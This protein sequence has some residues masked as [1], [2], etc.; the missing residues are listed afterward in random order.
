[1]TGT[2]VE[3]TGYA[4]FGER[5]NTGFQTQK[6]FIGERHDPETGLIYLNAR[7]MDP[8]FG[9]FISPDDWDPIMEGVGT[10][11]YAYALND[12]VNK[13][14]NNGH[15]AISLTEW[16]MIA[17]GLAVSYGAKKAIDEINDRFPGLFSEE[18]PDEE[19]V[20]MGGEG[21]ETA[22][23][24]DVVDTVTE[25]A[26]EGPHGLEV[27]PEQGD[28]TMENVKGLAGASKPKS[29]TT[30]AGPGVAVDIGPTRVVDRPG[31]KKTSGRTI[32][33]QR[34]PRHN[35][36]GPKVRVQEQPEPVAKEEEQAEGDDDSTEQ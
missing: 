20:D 3:Q 28:R 25:G 10:N 24:A 33:V 18:A 31:S 16:G 6:G 13:A 34:G 4:A 35:R 1:M 5:L 11:R 30:Q 21:Q 2:V 26:I 29:I 22:S 9:R 12:P 32:E 17:I 7:Y 27:T 19:A 8:I 14:D 23:A 36:I 15:T